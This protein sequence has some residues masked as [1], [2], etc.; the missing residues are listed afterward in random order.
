MRAF[1]I[2]F[3]SENLEKTINVLKAQKRNA[4]LPHENIKILQNKI[5]VKDEIIKLIKTIKLRVFDSLSAVK[6][7]PTISDLQQ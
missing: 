4:D 3:S 2:S 6:N 7:N 5:V 1:G